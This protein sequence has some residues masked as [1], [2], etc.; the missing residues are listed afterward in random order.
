MMENTLTA[1]GDS[2]SFDIPDSPRDARERIEK[3]RDDVEAIKL[4]LADPD[5]RK[6][7]GKRMNS[8]QYL[9]WRRGALKAKTAKERELR[10]L[11]RWLHERRLKAKATKFDVDPQEPESLLALAN[12]LLQDLKRRDG[13]E[14][15]EME[16]AMADLIRDYFTGM[17]PSTS[18]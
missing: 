18:E 13:C 11:K 5:K 2:I 8:E 17:N 15:G 3:L 6:S 16:Y 1:E 12:N 14:F 9:K 10:F 4:Q 7:S